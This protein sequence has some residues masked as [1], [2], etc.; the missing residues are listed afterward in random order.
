M[1][2]RAREKRTPE[3]EREQFEA[4]GEYTYDYLHTQDG[5]GDAQ[6]PA[7]PSVQAVR[8]A[9]KRRRTHGFFKFLGLLT[10]LTIGL[11]GGPADAVPPGNG[12]CRG[13][14][15]KNA[16]GGRDGVGPGARAAT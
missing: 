13:Q 7:Q 4:Y 16:A 11:V 15:G 3:I 14:R 9:L 10:V 12:L 2:K 8:R 5:A 6:T 1:S